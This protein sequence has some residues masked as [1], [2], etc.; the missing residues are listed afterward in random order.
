MISS[1]KHQDFFNPALLEDD[2]HIIGVG[3]IGSHVAEQLA[4][5][6][7]THMHL[8]DFD[9]VEPA[10]V[11]N[12][13]YF[14]YQIGQ[15]KLESMEQLL[16][17]INPDIELSLYVNGYKTQNLTGYIFLCVD[18]IDLRRTIVEMHHYNTNIKAMFDFR[19]GLTDAQHYAADWADDK[20]ICTLLDT[21]QF[22][23][24][25]A[26]EATPVSACGTTLSIL[27]TIRQ[28]TAFGVSNWINMILGKKLQKMIL[29]DAFNYTT[30]NY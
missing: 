5:L 15:S 27:P 14:D 24:E 1:I 26:K 16:K 6:G 10:N 4:R 21:M 30:Y 2:I 17:M 20:Q 3:A 11:A 29:C 18:N 9:V 7:V 23:H 25:E 8:Y 19:M 22:T 28:I 13:M 12:Q